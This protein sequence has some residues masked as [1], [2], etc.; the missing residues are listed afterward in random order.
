MLVTVPP[1]ADL[2]L[3]NHCTDREGFTLLGFELHEPGTRRC[4][5]HVRV[6]NDDDRQILCKTGRQPH[7]PH[8]R[9]ADVVAALEYRPNA[10][11]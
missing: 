6:A 5:R 4:I 3:S 1:F 2:L 9:V 8:G 7:G 10:T 11:I